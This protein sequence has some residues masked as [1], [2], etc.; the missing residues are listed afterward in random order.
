MR[1]QWH[2]GFDGAMD[3]ERS[4]RRLRDPDP[5]GAILQHAGAAEARL[6]THR[7]GKDVRVD[8]TLAEVRHHLLHDLLDQ[9]V[10]FVRPQ[11]A[12]GLVP[13]LALERVRCW[14]HTLVQGAFCTV[15]EQMSCPDRLGKGRRDVFPKRGTFN[16]RMGY[17]WTLDSIS[18]PLL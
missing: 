10:S 18:T 2:S 6:Q 17:A 8:E 7:L 9:P 16:G 11:P 4:V 13:A 12:L 1:S 3:L 15:H 5:S 14:W